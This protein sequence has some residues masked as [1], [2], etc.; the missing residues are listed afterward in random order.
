MRALCG[1]LSRSVFSAIVLGLCL[2][3]SSRADDQQKPKGKGKG[4]KEGVVQLDLSK[5]PPELARQV[6]AYLGKGKGKAPFFGK[7]KAPVVVTRAY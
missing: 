7:G 5:L 6:R 1:W 4:A 3:G 2:C